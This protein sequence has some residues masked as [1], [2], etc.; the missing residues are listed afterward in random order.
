MSTSQAA[1]HESWLVRC[2][3]HVPV[4]ATFTPD[5]T[6][7]KHSQWANLQ[8]ISTQ[9]LPR[10]TA[11]GQQ[12]TNK[13]PFHCPHTFISLL[14]VGTYLAPASP[15]NL[16]FFQACINTTRKDSC[17][18]S[19]MVAVLTDTFATSIQPYPSQL[20]LS[21]GTHLSI[22]TVSIAPPYMESFMR[23]SQALL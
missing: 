13:Y 2:S 9:L 11:K 1:A 8:H 14:P 12:S 15:Q 6:L 17:K 18:N 3:P 22:K 20:Y 7:G 23:F 19:T 10:I 21:K 5:Q 16:F 4:L